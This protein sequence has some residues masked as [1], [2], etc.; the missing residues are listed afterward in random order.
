MKTLI[1]YSPEV[2]EGAVRMVREHQGEHESQWAAIRS[3]AIKRGCTAETLRRWVR[4]TRRHSGCPLHGG[5][6]D[7]AQRAKGRGAR[8]ACQA[9]N[10]RSG[11]AVPTGS[12]EAAI[13]GGPP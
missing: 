12:R 3:I 13:Q 4:V 5:K 9:D 2:R 6:A 8:Q 7:A 11:H 1:K 10:Q